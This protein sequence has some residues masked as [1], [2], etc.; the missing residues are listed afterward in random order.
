[1]SDSLG[2]G[3][4]GSHNRRFDGTRAWT[5][6]PQGDPRSMYSVNDEC[7]GEQASGRSYH[8]AYKP[9]KVDG[10]DDVTGELLE[11]RADDTED[12]MKARIASFE[13][14]TAAVLAA[15]L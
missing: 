11:R 4:V 13:V 5:S 9:P 7:N 3:G 1:M 2:S 6:N 8:L 15:C 14:R 12:T 10:K